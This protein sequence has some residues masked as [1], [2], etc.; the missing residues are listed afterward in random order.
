MKTAGIIAEYNPFHNGHKYH[1]RRTREQTGADHLVCVMSGDFVQRGDIAVVDKFVR[2]RAALENGVDLVLELP[3]Q[4]ALGSAR[5]FA[6]AA[7]GMLDMLG[8]VDI[9]SFGSE[10]AD[11]D[12]LSNA[13]RASDNADKDSISR[14]IKDGLSYP[15]ALSKAL[16]DMGCDEKT[17][18]AL[19]SPNDI[20]AA[21]YLRAISALSSDMIPLAVKR[22][23]AGHDGDGGENGF[24]SAMEIRRRISAGL[25]VSEFMPYNINKDTADISRLETA[26]LA[27]L[28]GLTPEDIS[29]L[30]DVNNGGE[31]RIYRAIREST[32]LDTLYA[33]IKSKSSTLSKARRLVLCALLGVTQDIADCPPAYIRV[34]GMNGRGK[35]ILA[36]SSCPLPIDT[37][38]FALSQ[39][40]P[41]AKRQAALQSYA[42]DLY[43]LTFEQKKPCGGDYTAKPVILP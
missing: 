1:I 31:N 41:A 3:A 19:A 8:C 25:D 16:Y 43:A 38:L 22:T 14:Y 11:V 12:V 28:R 29:A 7:V 17:L 37:S 35:E 21:E 20:L 26:I 39:K 30:P 24:L 18:A 6:S 40:S 5:R 15:A 10:C 32:S 2:A 13:A 34:L 9:L 42:R 4:Y 33:L 36:A 23:G 27:K